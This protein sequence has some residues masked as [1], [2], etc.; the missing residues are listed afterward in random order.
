MEGG[1]VMDGVG[2]V[3]PGRWHSNSP[4]WLPPTAQPPY[5]GCVVKGVGAGEPILTPPFNIPV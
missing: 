4:A 2:D 3:K 1:G 5:T